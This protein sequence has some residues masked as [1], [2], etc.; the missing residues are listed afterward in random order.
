MAHHLKFFRF[1]NRSHVA[2]DD[3]TMEQFFGDSQEVDESAPRLDPLLAREGPRKTADSEDA[4][5]LFSTRE[6]LKPE[7]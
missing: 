3:L 1:S 5:P 4:E 2:T 6:E 7:E